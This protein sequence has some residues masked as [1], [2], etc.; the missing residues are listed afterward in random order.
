MSE[1]TFD[2]ASLFDRR[3]DRRWERVCGADLV[4]RNTWSAPDKEALVGWSGAY[5]EDR[6]ERLT[7]RQ[8]D[9]LANQVGHGLRAAGVGRGDRVV[10]VGENSVEGFVLR[11]GVAKIGAVVAY[12]NPALAPDVVEHLL[13]RYDP[14]FAVVDAELWDRVAAPFAAR[15]LSLDVT[16]EIGGGVVAGSIGFGAFVDAQPTDEPEA[17]VHGDDIWEIQ[18]TSGTT[19][20]PKGVMLSHSSATMVAHGF[21][22]TLTRGV[23]IENDVRLVA[24]LPMLYHIG[25][26]IFG[27]SV[28]ACGGTLVL[29]RRPD[30]EAVADAI[31]RERATALWGGAPAMYG[32]VLAANR[33]RRR[34]MSS[35]R[36]GVFGWAALRTD[37]LE[38]LREFAP[39][40]SPVGIFG[41]TEA[42]AC[43]R[44]WIDAHEELWR[45]TSPGLNYVGVPSPLLASQIVDALGE[46]LDGQAGVTGEAVYRSPVMTAGYYQDEA[47]TR[48][49]FR[50]GWFHSG[51]SCVYDERGMRIMV[52]RFKDIVKSGGENVSSI[53]V[54]GCLGQHPGVAK[55]AVIGVPDDR[56]GEAVTAVVVPEGDGVFEA[57]LIAFARERLAGFETPKQV[58]FVDALPETVGGKVLKYRLREQYR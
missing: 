41:Q 20:M 48:E 44:W 35:L 21:A 49:A 28:F 15:G 42:I 54:E 1:Q 30:V 39:H 26:Q 53:R 43:H 52:D 22:L 8:L 6:F 14:R 27:L 25:S 23:P 5:G 7:Y 50:G 9:E 2:V 24:F 16:I 31:E 45:E 58:V 10:A 18:S 36:I 32:A 51:D 40:L 19:A 56:W 55:V 37:V 46:P 11:L 38:G 17:T 13:E 29:G 12:L 57:D 3:A 47:A 33:A 34:D 4:E